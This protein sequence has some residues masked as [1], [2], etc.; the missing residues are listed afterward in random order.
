VGIGI[1]LYM[2]F[3]S[4][5][6]NIASQSVQR[7]TIQPRALA[8]NRLDDPAFVMSF[9]IEPAQKKTHYTNAKKIRAF[10]LGLIIFEPKVEVARC[11]LK[12][13]ISSDQRSFYIKEL[14]KKGRALDM[15]EIVTN[16]SLQGPG[17]KY[18]KSLD[19]PTQLMVAQ[20]F[21]SSFPADLHQFFNLITKAV[22]ILITGVT[23]GMLTFGGAIAKTAR[24]IFED[25]PPLSPVF[26][27]AFMLGA[28]A[29]YEAIDTRKKLA[30]KAQEML[31]SGNMTCKEARRL[32]L[33]TVKH[34]GNQSEI[35]GYL[36]C[37][38]EG[39]K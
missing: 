12:H 3:N 34:F 31:E 5:R 2:T 10:C 8:F 6:A 23:L 1:I 17:R 39:R 19:E 13:D 18:G 37:E 35:P 7:S 27:V 16:A 22:P 25:G 9:D 30:H 28:I 15:H 4:P 32:I 20:K 26:T 11:G 21:R 24:S 38:M 36:R 33:E 14:I 29:V